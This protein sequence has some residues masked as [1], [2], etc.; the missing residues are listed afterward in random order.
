M[1]DLAFSDDD[2]PE[3]IA[4]LARTVR[5]RSSVSVAGDLATARD[6]VIPTDADPRIGW[7][8][9]KPT[10]RAHVGRAFHGSEGTRT[11]SHE[12]VAA[13]E[14]AIATMWRDQR[15]KAVWLEEDLWTVVLRLLDAASNDRSVDLEIAAAKLAK[16]KPVRIAAV[17]ANVSWSSGPVV[18]G[19]IGLASIGSEEDADALAN[20]LSLEET[21][22]EA[23]RSHAKQLLRE[24]GTY[25]VATG[26]SP[27]Q[28]A[29][30]QQDFNRALDDLVG[31]VLLLSD[32]LEANGVYSLR[33]ATNRP[34]I[35]GIAL[36]RGAVG[37][38]LAKKE[39]ASSRLEC[40]RLA[41]GARPTSSNGTVPIHYRSTSYSRAMSP[42][43]SLT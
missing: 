15:V 17:L 31:L 39:P 4:G 30:G 1:D 41:T 21:D 28:V 7:A 22:K 23:F 25:V 10:Y 32:E 36:D 33:G 11:L 16:P 35:R 42:S 13:L 8:W 18:L 9:M 24:F 19:S 2:A 38:L 37:D 27:R 3:V 34:G 20:L 14:S 26:Q 40:F 5:G 43:S 12:G 6:C 29:L